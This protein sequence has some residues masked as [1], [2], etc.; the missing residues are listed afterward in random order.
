MTAHARS[1]STGAA[2]RSVPEK[3]IPPGTVGASQAAVTIAADGV[4]FD[5]DGVLVD[6]V[7][8]VTTAWSRWAGVYG[9][10][11]EIVSD[12]IHG[13]RAADIVA[14]LIGDTRQETA[15][16]EIKTLEVED[17]P[18][19][20][21]IPGAIELISEIAQGRWA[22]VTSGDR[23]LATA[24]LAAAGVAAPAVV[25]TADDVTHG[26]PHPEG[27][28]SAAAQ[29]GIRPD[30]LVVME[31][32]DAGVR[33]ARAAGVGVVIGVG[34]RALE[35]DADV[36]V[37]DLTYVSWTGGGLRIEPEGLLRGTAA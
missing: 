28:R 4:L 29:L 36:V 7:E 26:K 11:A 24:R 20:T 21:S 25:V 14:Q 23:T 27:Y 22:V 15:L 32:A 6:S 10:D 19:V 17:A 3:Q 33:A 9:F 5:N 1:G 31:D 34:P 35:S 18:S 12:M 8:S 16:N 2:T 37:H 30:R 13:R